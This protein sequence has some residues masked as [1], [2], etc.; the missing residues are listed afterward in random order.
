MSV[1]TGPWLAQPVFTSPTR[2][3]WGGASGTPMLASDSSLV[4]LACT[5]DVPGDPDFFTVVCDGVRTLASKVV[6]QGVKGCG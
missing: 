4:L 6:G 2:L 3:V 5:L 1:D